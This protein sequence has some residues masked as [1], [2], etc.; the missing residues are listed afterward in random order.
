MANN[1]QST[2]TRA[3]KKASSDSHPR[4]KK[5]ISPWLYH[6]ELLELLGWF[7]HLDFSF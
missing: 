2:G 4:K 5:K 3:Q 1:Q 7:V 6:P